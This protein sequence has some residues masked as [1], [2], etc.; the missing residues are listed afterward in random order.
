MFS[1]RAD[2]DIYLGGQD[3]AAAPSSDISEVNV[4]DL[5]NR[6]DLL[7]REIASAAGTPDHGRI[8]RLRFRR[9]PVVIASYPCRFARAGPMV[10]HDDLLP[11]DPHPCAF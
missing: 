8:L 11:K 9:Y 5:L 1:L 3:C 7:L 4:Q 2:T 6:S 10:R